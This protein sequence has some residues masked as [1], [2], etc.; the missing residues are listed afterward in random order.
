MTRHAFQGNSLGFE[1]MYVVKTCAVFGQRIINAREAGKPGISP[2]V[3]GTPI[4]K[5]A[6]P[7][8]RPSFLASGVPE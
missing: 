2:N 6:C 4:S 7:S 5:A 8:L 3:S 1:D